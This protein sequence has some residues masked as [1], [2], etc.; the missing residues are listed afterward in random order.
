MRVLKR[1]TDLVIS[2]GLMLLLSPILLVR[3]LY[4]K[5]VCGT[6]FEKQEC[7]TKGGKSFFLHTFVRKDGKTTWM[8][9]LP[10]L[11]D[12]FRGKMS[13]VGPRP[14]T[15]KEMDALIKENPRYFYR[16]RVQAGL[17]GYAQV[18]GKK[19]SVQEDLLKLDLIYIQH[20]SAL[21]DMKL[22]LLSLQ[23]ESRQ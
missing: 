22:M 15:K 12:V 18:Y 13:V 10:M 16:L 20:F 19:T 11:W 21:M 2:G 1:L 6:V 14:L 4:G 23:G 3:I 7:T 9:S 5:A 17:T 8:T